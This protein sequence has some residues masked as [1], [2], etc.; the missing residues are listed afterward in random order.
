VDTSF[1]DRLL[2]MS[3]M[4]SHVSMNNIWSSNMSQAASY[5]P[6]HAGPGGWIGTSLNNSAYPDIQQMVYNPQLC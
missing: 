3:S 5:M 1:A 4:S 6:A 2:S